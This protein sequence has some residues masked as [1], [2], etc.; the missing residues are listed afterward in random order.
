MQFGRPSGKKTANRRKAVKDLRVIRCLDSLE[1]RLEKRQT[2]RTLL[3]IATTSRDGWNSLYTLIAGRDPLLQG[4]LAAAIKRT[5]D[6]LEK[7]LG[8][9]RYK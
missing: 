6:S 2:V 3:N 1:T 8:D 5:A 7:V 9:F 4:E